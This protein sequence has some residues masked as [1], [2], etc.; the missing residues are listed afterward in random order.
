L[1]AIRWA[2]QLIIRACE[3]LQRASDIQQLA[4]WKRKQQDVVRPGHEPTLA[5][6]PHDPKAKYQSIRATAK[7]GSA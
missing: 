1:D 4:V 2:R 5:V 7:G 6:A 3:H